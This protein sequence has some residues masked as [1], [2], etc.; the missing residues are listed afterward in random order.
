MANTLL[1]IATILLVLGFGSSGALAGAYGIAIALAM[2]I[3]SVLILVWLLQRNSSGSRAL[4]VVMSAILVIDLVFCAAN[5]QKLT[6]GGWVP[7]VMAGALFVVMNT[8]TRGRVVV[9]RQIARERHSVHELRQRLAANPPL[10]APGTAVFL[11]SN[12]D[13][14]PR[15]LWHNLQYN[16]VLHGEVILLSMITEEVPRVQAYRR[17]ETSEVLPG[18]TRVVARSG[19]ME[20]P[21]VN[22]ILYEASRLGVRYKPAETTF[23]V[24]SESIFFGRSSLRAWEKRLF[25]FLMRNSRRAASFYGVPES[26]LVEFG[27]RLGV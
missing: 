24:G 25:A 23:F 26:R 14:L 5:M 22:E 4:F 7:A 6:D 2:A 1:A 10:R 16:N 15:A 8:W 9:A 18:I 19:F 21:R 12:P 17:I 11:A 20:T 13:G 27:T 3:D